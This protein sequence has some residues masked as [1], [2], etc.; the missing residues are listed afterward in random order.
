MSFLSKLKSAVPHISLPK[1]EIDLPKLPKPQNVVKPLAK[2][3]DFARDTFETVKDAP[4]NAL[5]DMGREGLRV[6]Y[7]GADRFIPD[8]VK[9]KGLGVA[10]LGLDVLDK[11]ASKVLGEDSKPASIIH[12]LARVDLEGITRDDGLKADWGKLWGTWLFEE[13]P[14]SLGKWDKTD[15]GVDR[16]TVTDPSYISDVAGR[17]HQK[18]ALDEFLKQHPNPQPG[19]K[20][21]TTGPDG[22]PREGKLFLFTGPET[23]EGGDYTA[24]EWFLGSYHTTIKCTGLDPKT[25][26]PQLQFQVTNTSHWESATRLP[27]SFQDKGLPPSLVGDRNRDQG[28]GLGGGFIQR[29]QWNQTVDVP[30]PARPGVS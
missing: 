15:E 18:E 26:K 20:L 1:P 3:V 12:D 21:T 30:T 9:E 4:K 25:G 10:E 28:V 11:G 29:Y 17:P 8:A 5:R 16:V 24:A 22:K 2:T 14:A 23:A 27:Q 6:A 7:H 19:D 13:K